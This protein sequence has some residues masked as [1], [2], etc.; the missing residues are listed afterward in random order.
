MKNSNSNKNDERVPFEVSLQE[1]LKLDVIA[2]TAYIFS[3]DF[4]KSISEL[5][6]NVFA[7]FE[8]CI[9]ETANGIPTVS[10]IF[11]HGQYDE[12]ATVACS[13]LGDKTVGSSIIDRTR[14]RDRQLTEGDRYYLTDDG[15][16]AIKQILIP[17]I[18][19]NGNPNWKTIVSDWTDR[20]VNTMYTFQ[21]PVQY[22]KIAFCDLNR[23]CSI[24]YG[25]KDSD[26]NKVEYDV[27]IKSPWGPAGNTNS[28]IVSNYILAVTKVNAK[29]V[30]SM[31]EK[32]G[33]GTYGSNIVR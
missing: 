33:Y 31:Y 5:Y 12:G 32:L 10:L 2:E 7:D 26:G 9:F 17:R 8:G 16:D 22:T 15:K 3:S 27:T 19:N 20:N 11:N 21:Q 1:P 13:R 6:R 18:Y 4:C 24:L 29:E 23:L 14:S 30:R 25:D 28:G